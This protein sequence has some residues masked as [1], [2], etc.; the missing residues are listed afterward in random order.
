MATAGNEYCTI[1]C[2]QAA[3]R[4]GTAPPPRPQAT[5][6]FPD[7]RPERAGQQV[8][9]I[10]F[11]YPDREEPWDLTCQASFLGNFYPLKEVLNMEAYGQQRQFQNAEAAFQALKFWRSPRADEFEH[12]TGDEAFRLKQQL[13]GQEDW[14]YG[15]RGTNW[16][17]MW[18]VLQAKF[19]NPTM[20]D[21][22][23][24]TGDAFLLEHNSCQGRDT[25]WSDNED[26]TGSNWLGLQLMLLRQVLAGDSPSL[27][28]YWKD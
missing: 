16:N 17:G 3:D 18:D 13:K 28:A 6:N 25:V 7:P 20:R 15:D 23:V 8:G 11:Y 24:A 14:T 27:R 1:Q 9:V 19:S 2:K 22:L 4:A 5:Y 12:A 26:G 10:A 21:A